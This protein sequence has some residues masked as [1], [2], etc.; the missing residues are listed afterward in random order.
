ML[1]FRLESYDETSIFV[2]L[3]DDVAEPVKGVIQ[4]LHGMGEY[5]GRYDE[6]ARYFNSKGYIVF[7]DDHRAH[8][9]TETDASR[10]NHFGD[11]FH[12]TLKDELFFRD[13]LKNKYQHLPVFL[14]GHSYG[15]FL[16]QAFAQ[17]G[18]D[19]KAIALL[20]T[21]HMKSIFTLGKILTAPIWLVARDWKPKFVD[22]F[23]RTH[24]K[25][26]GDSGDSQWLNS[27][28]ERREEFDDDKYVHVPMSV[29]FDYSMMKAV[30]NLYSKQALSL[31]NPGTAIGVFCGDGDPVGDYGKGA[32]KLCDMYRSLDITC[33][34][35]LYEGA[36]HEI[37]FD[38]CADRVRED[39]VDFFDKFIIFH[40]TTIDELYADVSGTSSDDLDSDDRDVPNSYASENRD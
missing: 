36:R 12:K 26:K 17:Q 23:S 33:E 35:H 3:W 37:A 5:A 8:G 18:T 14:L 20:G 28:K 25:Y 40:Q 38:H 27:V 9:R 31:L 19:V 29:N 6:L 24:Y 32:K 30:S 22:K 15:S 16:A 2:T 13:W 39:I 11:I 1:C 34:F 10:G 21:G 4:L 7:A